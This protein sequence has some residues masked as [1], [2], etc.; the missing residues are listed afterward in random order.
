MNDLELR[1]SFQLSELERSLLDAARHE[2]V[3]PALGA[4]MADALG[5]Q[6]SGAGAGALAG[7]S[8]TSTA[9]SASVGA[10]LF[11]KLGLWG[12]LS[13]GV[14][15]AA[16]WQFMRPSD[17]AH[18]GEPAAPAGA[19]A[20]VTEPAVVQPESIRPAAVPEVQ[21]IAPSVRASGVRASAP[22]DDAALLAEIS[23]LDRARTAL[24]ERASGRAVA[25]LD[26][27]A[28]RFARGKLAP[29]AAALRIEALVQRGSHAQARAMAQKFV[30]AYPSHPL[31]AQ[32]A[33]LTQPG[34]SPTLFVIDAR[35]PEH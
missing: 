12:V 1:T 25:L 2:H 35:A 17:V 19:P 31:S 21:A 10:P 23:L 3:P 29:E 4:R 32:V 16:S 9:A 18:P 34:E 20:A 11:A 22:S 6:W 24:R 14:I 33:K 5:M 15:A 28:R 7:T 26:Q 13:A 27:H 8:T 30:R